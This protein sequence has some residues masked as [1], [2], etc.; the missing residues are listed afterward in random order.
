LILTI[1]EA[2]EWLRID[3][4]YENTTIQ[5]LINAAELYIKNATGKTFDS[6]NELAKL[7]CLVLVT[8]WYENR[9]L[10]GQKPSDKVRFTIQS[11][12]AQLRYAPTG[13]ETNEVQSD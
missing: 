1:E 3:G 9:E 12:L 2:K 4:D 8:D 11:M 10:V 6:T 7:F 5:M 13:G